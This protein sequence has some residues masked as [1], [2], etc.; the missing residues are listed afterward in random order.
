MK[1]KALFT[2]PVLVV[3][4][5]LALSAQVKALDAGTYFW[6][7]TNDGRTPSA[8]QGAGA[9]D[10]TLVNVPG[11][12]GDVT[13]YAWG[14]HGYG[15]L[16]FEDTD[17]VG[18]PIPGTCYSKREGNEIKGWARIL[19]IKND[20]LLGNSGG[21][22]GFVQLD[23]VSID[24]ATNTLSGY[25]WSPELGFI[26]FDGLVGSL[27]LRYGDCSGLE[28]ESAFTLQQ[29]LT[30]TIVACNGAVNITNGPTGWLESG[31]DAVKVKV[32]GQKR[33][34]TATASSRTET[35]TASRNGASDSVAI[36]AIAC[37][38]THCKDNTCVGKRCTN[39]CG[40]QEDGTLICKPDGFRE[41]VP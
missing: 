20:E 24:S 9:F 1:I 8:Y 34:I 40:D 38:P 33:E 6:G 29:G 5:L 12:D 14:G 16:S 19:T 31:D 22:S 27:V 13:G 26:E 37:V 10:A 39:T 35:V 30:K 7:G 4:F 18:C 28:V 32:K 25:A 41:V 11:G 21:W 3:V 23:G 15:W 17:A 2:F 36:T